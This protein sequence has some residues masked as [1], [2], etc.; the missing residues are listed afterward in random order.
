MGFNFTK[1]A[2]TTF[3]NSI[4]AYKVT[5]PS[6]FVYCWC[7]NITSACMI[8]YAQIDWLGTVF[9]LPSFTYVLLN[10]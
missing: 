2:N 6:S 10:N 8:D 7:S 4:G 1:W 5:F 9:T 3:I